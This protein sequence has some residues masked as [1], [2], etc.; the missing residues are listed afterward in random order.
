[1]MSKMKHSISG[2]FNELNVLNIWILWY[3]WTT[4]K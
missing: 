2:G 4:C 1:M 3:S